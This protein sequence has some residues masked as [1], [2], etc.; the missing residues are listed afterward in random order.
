MP[1]FDL[2]MMKDQEG[3]LVFLEP[4]FRDHKVRGYNDGGDRKRKWK[5]GE[6]NVSLVW[7]PLV[8]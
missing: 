2:K 8:F 3:T 6:L 1:R 7:Q 5:M 4:K